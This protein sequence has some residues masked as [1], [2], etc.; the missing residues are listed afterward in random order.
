MSY[1]AIIDDSVVVRKIVETSM[2]RM[3]IRCS[4]FRDGY[5]ALHTLGNEQGPLPD[6]LFL[7]INL[8]RLDG[9]EL[10]RLFKSNP[11]F[12]SIVII[13]LSSRDSVL[14]RVK[15]RLAGAQAY[16]VKP[17]RTQDLQALVTEHL[18]TPRLEETQPLNITWPTNSHARLRDHRDNAG[19]QTLSDAYRRPAIVTENIF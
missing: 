3:G 13:I 2:G 4:G 1:V 10:L 17:F 12:A 16:L 14:D 19:Q 8:P 15:F 5:E 7:D 18:S 9:F 6:L 11:R